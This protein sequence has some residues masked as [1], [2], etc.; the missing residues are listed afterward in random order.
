M[1]PSKSILT[2]IK[3]LVPVQ[4]RPFLRRLLPAPIEP[5]HYKTIPPEDMEI[6]ICLRDAWK[7]A[8]IPAAQRAI[9]NAEL[10]RMYQG[11][12]IP[13]FRILAEAVRMT[14]HEETSI[15]EVGCAT[16]HYSEVLA[17]QL[18]HP[19]KY[20][21]IDYSPALLTEARRYYPQQEFV[22]GDATR[23]PLDDK[24]VELLISGCV[25]L[26]VPDY[27]RVISESA[28]IARKWVIFHRTPVVAG[29]TI[30]FTKLA[31]GV[32]CL[33]IAF[34]ER[35]LFDLFAKNNLN[36]VHTYEID[37]PSAPH[38]STRGYGRTFVCRVI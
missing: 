4:L 38:I 8:S 5:D 10:Q 29:S 17:C 18:G 22:L 1:Y 7:D 12:V 14:H 9:V 16:G 20:I 25:L 26:H 3:H 15:V 37:E 23:L 11:E 28:R 19:I 24:C 32:P 13:I 34:G 33:E 27:E 31:Y 6:E 30:H 35:E 36:V 21:G 2:W